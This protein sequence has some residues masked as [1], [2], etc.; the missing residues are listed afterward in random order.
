MTKCSGGDNDRSNDVND[1]LIMAMMST[2]WSPHMS[3]GCPYWLSVSLSETECIQGQDD[4]DCDVN[5]DCDGDDD[6]FQDDI[7]DNDDCDND[8]D[9]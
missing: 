9:E 2:N 4:D 8:V 6:D 7:C 3:K 1:E 5:D